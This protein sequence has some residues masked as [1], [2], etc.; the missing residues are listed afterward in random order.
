MD[1][2]RRVIF[3]EG[4]WNTTTRKIAEEAGISLA[5]IHYYFANKDELLVAVYEEMIES[6][7]RLA[8]E[9]FAKPGTL[10]E[11]IDEVVERTW[12]FTRQNMDGQLMQAE[13]MAYALR[14]G[15]R[16]LAMRQ[17]REYLDIY[18]RVLLS[19]SD[20]AGRTDLDLQGLAQLLLAAIDGIIVAHTIE[21]DEGRTTDSFRRLVDVAH[22]YPLTP[23]KKPLT[24]LTLTAPKHARRRS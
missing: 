8:A 13:L 9:D 21:P 20:V 3:R 2:G 6:V 10:A 5:T 17:G 11:R 14:N 12:Q 19:A 4:I 24:P 7:R 16:D 15:M 23:D 22:Q 1:A 18:R